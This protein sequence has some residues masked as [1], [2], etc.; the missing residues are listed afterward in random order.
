MKISEESN[1]HAN[2]D[3]TNKK[4]LTGATIASQGKEVIVDACM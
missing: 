4:T 1:Y 2:I 3:K